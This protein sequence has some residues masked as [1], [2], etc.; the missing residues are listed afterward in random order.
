MMTNQAAASGL[1]GAHLNLSH[2]SLFLFYIYIYIYIFFFKCFSFII[3][4]FL[5][6][7]GVFVNLCVC[8]CLGIYFAGF[9]TRNQ[10]LSISACSILSTLS[11]VLKKW[12][13]HVPLERHC[14]S[15]GPSHCLNETGIIISILLTLILQDTASGW[16]GINFLFFRLRCFLI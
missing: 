3:S 12:T 8:V 11:S 16:A 15:P 9:G 10:L 1:L 4:W 13:R 6:S 7:G 14:P 2:L 5:L